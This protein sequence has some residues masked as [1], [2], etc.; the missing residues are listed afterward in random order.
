M[1]HV[2]QNRG[3]HT[4]RTTR[5][6]IQ[7]CETRNATGLARSSASP[8]ATSMLTAP[9]RPCVW[10]RRKTLPDPEKRPRKICPRLTP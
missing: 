3:T 2:E 10:A 6:A 8:R 4:A 9:Q 1:G 5:T 7:P